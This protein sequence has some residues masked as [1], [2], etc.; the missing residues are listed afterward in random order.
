MQAAKHSLHQL[1]KKRHIDPKCRKS[2]PP[3][4]VEYF[5]GYESKS[6]GFAYI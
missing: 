3:Y 2:P 5:V 6:N 1:R 4:R